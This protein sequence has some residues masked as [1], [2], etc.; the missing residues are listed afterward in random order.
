MTQRRLFLVNLLGAT[1]V[2]DEVAHWE[3]AHAPLFAQTPGLLG[4]VQYRPLSEEWGRGLR[5]V[6]SSTV[7]ADAEAERAAYASDFYRDMVTPD[8]AGFLDRDSA[9]SA[10]VACEPRQAL[11]EQA[12]HDFVVLRFGGTRPDASWRTIAT[13]RA[14]AGGGTEI[15]V[16]GTSDRSV[17]LSLS[18]AATVPTIACR[19]A[20]I[21]LRS[22]VR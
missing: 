10:R 21:P 13:S 16:L 14:T 1:S 3:L 6:C 4:Y 7:F 20:T 2:H 19:P 17:A 18:A 5:Q 12:L 22:E 11:D 15:H 9:W 8:E